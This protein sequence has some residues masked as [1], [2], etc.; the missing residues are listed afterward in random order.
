MLSAFYIFA[1]CFALHQRR[2][3]DVTVLAVATVTADGVRTRG[4]RTTRVSGALVYIQAGCA[5]SDEAFLAKALIVYALGV[6]RAVK[7]RFT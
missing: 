6:V 2:R 3:A 1:W 4:E 7:V 5:F